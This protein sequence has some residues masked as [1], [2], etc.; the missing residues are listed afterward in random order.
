VTVVAHEVE[1]PWDGRRL[2]RFLTSLA[3]LALAV[4]LRLPGPAVAEPVHQP[5]AV[6]TVTEAVA[7]AEMER[8]QPRPTVPVTPPVTPIAGIPAGTPGVLTGV[9]PSTGDSRAPPAY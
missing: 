7:V 5:A 9:V 3:L 2:L 6:T 1:R 8:L 4:T